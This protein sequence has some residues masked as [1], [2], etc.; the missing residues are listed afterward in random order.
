MGFRAQ[1]IVGQNSAAVTTTGAGTQLCLSHDIGPLRVVPALKTQCEANWLVCESGQLLG[2][3]EFLM[4]FS[5]CYLE[6]RTPLKSAWDPKSKIVLCLFLC[7][8]ALVVIFSSLHSN[9]SLF[10]SSLKGFRYLVHGVGG[11]KEKEEEKEEEESGFPP[12]H[13]C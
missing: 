12:P 2:P 3:S 5:E 1:W 7:Y 11:E 6:V 9:C 4:N 8:C 10:Y 13:E